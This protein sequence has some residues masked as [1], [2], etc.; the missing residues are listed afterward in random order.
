M[1]ISKGL[2]SVALASAI[3]VVS[4]CAPKEEDQA[5][6]V[7]QEIEDKTKEI[8]EKAADKT[9][10][11]ASD[12]ADKSKEIVSATGEAIT[13]GWITTKLKAK[14]AD[15]KLLKDSKIDIDTNNHVVTLKGTV[16]SDAAKRRAATIAQGTEGVV[17]VVNQV[18]V[19]AN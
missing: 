16:G 9:K 1:S 18:V 5:K 11:V 3:G 12:V 17:N 15:E 7:V 2:I 10:E 8:A 4:A 6:K 13:D 14:F 19:K